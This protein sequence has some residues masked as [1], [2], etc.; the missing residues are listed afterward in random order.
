[1]TVCVIPRRSI[2]CSYA[3][4]IGIMNGAADPSSEKNRCRQQQSARE[5]V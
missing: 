3:R 1:V 2:E 5:P 4:A